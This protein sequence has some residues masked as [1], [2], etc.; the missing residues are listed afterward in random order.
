MCPYISKKGRR[1]TFCLFCL[2]TNRNQVEFMENIHILHTNDLHSYLENWPKMRRYLQ[3]KQ[4]EYQDET[5]ITV[6]LGDFCDRRHP[7]TEATNGQ[8]N[9]E[10]MNQANYD[11]VTIGN[12]EGIGNAKPELDQLYQAANF[13][14]VLANLYDATTLKNPE[15]AIPYKIITTKFGTKIGIT[16]A[17]AAFPL[18]YRPNGWDIRHWSEILPKLIQ[19]LRQKVD[20]VIL[21]SHL[22]INEDEKIAAELPEIDLIIGSHTHHHFPNGHFE[23]GVLLAAADRYGTHI[24]EVEF[25]LN[26]QHQIVD[27]KAFTVATASLP[28]K[29][30][31]EVEITSYLLQGA[32]KLGQNQIAYLKEALPVAHADTCLIDEALKALKKRSGCEAAV[33]NTGLFLHGLPKGAISQKDLHDLLPHPMRVMKVTLLGS[34]LVRLVREMEKNRLFL[35]N[36]PIRGMGFRGKIFGEIVYDGIFYDAINQ[37]VF[38]KGKKVDPE[39]TY[40]LATVDHYLFIPFFPTIEIASEY[41]LLFPEFLRQVVGDYLQQQYPLVKD[42]QT[43]GNKV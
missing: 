8:A 1:E 35:Q 25:Q 37:V 7:L 16:A 6:D 19:K 27:K 14:V 11:V 39:K 38:W 28:E 18:T 24:G 4:K 12:N 15:W 10:L 22:G 9:I 41:E 26:E 40:T 3:I 5:V 17:T 36:Y 2:E 20:V 23:N 30:A 21:L 34:D 32:E 29:A 42:T 31:D 33:L 43:K 13:E